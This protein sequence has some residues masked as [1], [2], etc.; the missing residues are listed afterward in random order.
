MKSIRFLAIIGLVFLLTACPY[1]STVPLGE[2]EIKVES[3]YYGKW[4]KSGSSEN[5]D[6]YQFG[7]M[8][9]YRFTVDD[10][11][12]NSSDSVYNNDG[13]YIA[14]F[15][16]LGSVRFVNMKKDGKFYFYKIEMK[17][18]DEF[19]LHEVTDNIDESFTD[20]RS[21][22]N[23]F[24][25]HKDLSFFYNKDEKTYNKASDPKEMTPVKT[26]TKGRSQ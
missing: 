8:D 5:P 1:S 19:V 24:D 21:L 15:T 10:F 20:S 3:F 7:K 18:N 4:E 11:K 17:G 16:D 22:R 13:T 2:P 26:R 9:D 23:F 6:Y 12:Y 14:H 25:Q